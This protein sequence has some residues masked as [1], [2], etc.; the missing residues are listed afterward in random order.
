[1]ERRSLLERPVRRAV[2]RFPRRLEGHCELRAHPEVLAPLAREEERDLPGRFAETERAPVGKREGPGRR[3]FDPLRGRLELRCEVGP[4]RRDEGEARLR[5]G[6]VRPQAGAGEDVERRA[7][8][9]P[10][11]ELARLAH[12]VG[13]VRAAGDDELPAEGLKPLRARGRSP[14]L[15]EGHVEVGAPEAEGADGGP[16]R[17]VCPADPGARLGAQVERALLEV[18]LRVRGVDLDARREDLVVERHHGLEEARGAGGGL[19]VADLA[20]DRAERAPLPV[21]LLRSRRRRSGAPR[22]RPRR[23]PSSRSRAPRRAR[24][25]RGR[26]PPSA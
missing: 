20:L 4:A 12:H 1:M 5:A 16:A 10:G 26:S 22:T 11:R 18:E 13:P 21:A 3:F 23:P 15:L 7:R 9:R 17:V 8:P 6:V 14:V 19:G 2:P 24:R 25:S